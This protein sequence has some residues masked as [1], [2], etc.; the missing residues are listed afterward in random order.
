MSNALLCTISP[1]PH[2]AT[3]QYAAKDKSATFFTSSAN[4]RIA[5]TGQKRKLSHPHFPPKLCGIRTVRKYTVIDTTSICGIKFAFPYGWN[6]VWR[7]SIMPIVLRHLLSGHW[8]LVSIYLMHPKSYNSWR[9]EVRDSFPQGM[10]WLSE[11]SLLGKNCFSIFRTVVFF[12]NCSETIIFCVSHK[13]RWSAQLRCLD[14][15]NSLLS[16]HMFRWM[17]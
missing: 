8:L 15:L 11:L 10:W 2:E 5:L 1:F 16:V 14:N 9:I 4:G 7:R 12:V 6:N 17:V 3:I 13:Q